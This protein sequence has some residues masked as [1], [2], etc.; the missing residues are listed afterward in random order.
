MGYI[1]SNEYENYNGQGMSV[2]TNTP[3][4][5]SAMLPE[6]TWINPTTWGNATSNISNVNSMYNGAENWNA[7]QLDAANKLTIDAY[8]AGQLTK[9][10]PMNTA[11]GFSTNN[12]IDVGKLGLGAIG[13][14][15][16]MKFNKAQLGLARDKLAITQGVLADNRAYRKQLGNAWKVR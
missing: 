6:E 4:L 8:D 14:F 10:N 9:S 5:G 7:G 15:S 3:T 12:W 2:G 13:M 11:E 1:K 16:K